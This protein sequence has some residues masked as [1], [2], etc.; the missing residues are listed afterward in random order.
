[1]CIRDRYSRTAY[2]CSYGCSAANRQ[3]GKFITC[4]AVQRM[5]MCMSMCMCMHVP[6]CGIVLNTRLHCRLGAQHL[7]CNGCP[8]LFYCGGLG[9]SMSRWSARSTGALLHHSGSRI[10]RAAGVQMRRQPALQLRTTCATARRSAGDVA[11]GYGIILGEEA[12]VEKD[13]RK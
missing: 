4:A 10:R 7:S 6:Q 9:I 1:M 11:G 12:F 3:T 8:R 5:C 2:S 13:N